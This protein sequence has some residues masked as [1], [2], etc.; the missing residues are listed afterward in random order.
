MLVKIAE[1]KKEIEDAFRIREEVFVEEQKVPAEEELDEYDK[2]AAHF[3]VYIENMPVGAGRLRF[4]EDGCGKLERICI[5]KS[6]RGKSIGKHLMMKMEDEIKKRGK[7]KAKLHA[8]THAANFYKKLDYE[9]TSDEFMDAGIPHVTM[10]K[11]L[12]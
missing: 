8:Q 1:T 7:K 12:S 5:V 3:V 11:Y 4:T 2:A 9:V 10:I 6:Q